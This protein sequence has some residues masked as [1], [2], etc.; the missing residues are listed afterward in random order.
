VALVVTCLLTSLAAQAASPW[1][2]ED[3]V[4]AHARGLPVE[5]TRAIAA[6]VAPDPDAVV[7]VLRRGVPADT[8]SAWGV[9]VTEDEARTAAAL[10]VLAQPA[11][12][13]PAL[14]KVEAHVLDRAVVDATAMTA[15]E[16]RQAAKGRVHTRR[17]ASTL[18]TGVLFAVGGGMTFLA[19]TGFTL[20][21]EGDG[22]A[23]T[24]SPS[25][26][27]M[28][29][30]AAGMLVGGVSFSFSAHELELAGHYPNGWPPSVA[31]RE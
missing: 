8:V 24:T 15:E 5:T 4:V 31:L 11:T 2:A 18:A 19:G 23:S 16:A 7:Y 26:A 30:G 9:P 6:S 28:A 1:A 12:P 17:G 27:L 21:R 25:P 13:A 29:V 20:D 10:G 14:P 22:W 3:L